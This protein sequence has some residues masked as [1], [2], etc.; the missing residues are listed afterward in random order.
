MPLFKY[1]DRTDSFPR[2]YAD[3]PKEVQA[4]TERAISLLVD[5]LRHP[6]L[7]ARKIQGA[8]GI[9]E[10]RVTAHYR[11]TFKI[12]PEA[13]LQLRLVGTHDILKTP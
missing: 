7:K 11:I 10:A 9:W 3:L 6:S 8:E 4:R 5:N 1:V 2:D 12:L 13:I